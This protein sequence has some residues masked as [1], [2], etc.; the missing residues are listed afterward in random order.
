MK[1][2]LLLVLLVIFCIP[3]YCQDLYNTNDLFD[4][5]NKS[6]K[7]KDWF[8]AYFNHGL[9]NY[10]QGKKR[11]LPCEMGRDGFFLDPYGDIL[12]CNGMN[13]KQP[14]GN[15]YTQTWDDIWKSEQAQKVRETVNS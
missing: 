12:A 15:L 14:M 13:V 9:I 2:M 4:I 7:L 3:A 10:I 1:N 11:E 5:T 6:K 8:R